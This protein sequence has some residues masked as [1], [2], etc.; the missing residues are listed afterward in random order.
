MP[1][2]VHIPKPLLREIDRRARQLGVSRNRVIVRALE[3]D[4][5]ARAEWSPGFL[6]LLAQEGPRH[7]C[8]VDE[9]LRA[10][11][12]ARTSKKPPSL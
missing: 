4:L 3:N 12:G 11:R 5:R 10:I 2:S 9:M 7:A 6:E 8:D 1:T